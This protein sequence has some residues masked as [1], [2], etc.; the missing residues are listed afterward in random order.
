MGFLYTTQSMGSSNLAISD[1][2]VSVTQEI[3]L[4]TVC[5]R[6]LKHLVTFYKYLVEK[7]L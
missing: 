4:N 6:W 7:F 1:N 3:S 2:I 5:Y